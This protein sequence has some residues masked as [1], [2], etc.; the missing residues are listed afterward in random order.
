MVRDA[1]VGRELW[2]HYIHCLWDYKPGVQNCTDFDFN[3]GFIC[4]IHTSNGYGLLRTVIP[5]RH[6]KMAADYINIIYE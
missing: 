2:I 3:A 1:Q 6:F 4:L 5:V